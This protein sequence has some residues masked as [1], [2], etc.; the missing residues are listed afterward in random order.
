[1]PPASS[2]PPPSPSSLTSSPSPTR[3]TLP[4]SPAT[5]VLTCRATAPADYI[6][7]VTGT[8]GTLSHTTATIL[9]HVVDFSITSNP[10]SQSLAVGQSSQSASISLTRLNCFYRIVTLKDVMLL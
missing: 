2:P 9:F 5:S 7:T 3:P 10:S 1:Q 6:V 4:P 8:N